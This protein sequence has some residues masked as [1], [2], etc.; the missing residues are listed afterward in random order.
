MTSF[1][2]SERPA[3]DHMSV[4]AADHFGDDFDGAIPA[5]FANGQQQQGVNVAD[6]HRRARFWRGK[7]NARQ[8]HTEF[9]DDP[10]VERGAD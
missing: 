6:L 9:F 7:R 1:G 2:L 5:F 8:H 3:H 4:I 10:T